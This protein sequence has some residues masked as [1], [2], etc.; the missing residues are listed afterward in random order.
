MTFATMQ[1]EVQDALT[2]LSTST[3][4]TATMIKRWLNMAKDW[5]LAFKPWPFMEGTGTDLIDATG[6]YPYPTLMKTKSAFL[7]TVAGER[8]EK[9]RY[10]DYLDYLEQ[11]STGS[12]KVWAEFGRTI[13]INGNACSVGDAVIIYGQKMVA[14]L[15]GDTETTPFA[16]AEPSGDEAIVLRAIAKGFKKKEGFETEAKLAQLEAEATLN[17]IW[18]RIMEAKPREVLKTTP[19]FKKINIIKGTY[20]G[21]DP[22]NIGKFSV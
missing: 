12:D 2:V 21:T 13:Y 3:F 4:I 17:R 22:Y 6:N 9:I 16:S 1:T 20:E 11:Y 15:S 14:D 8:F 19:R 7:I 18:E 5:A 10:E